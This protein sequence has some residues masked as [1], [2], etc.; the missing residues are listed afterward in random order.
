MSEIIPR[1]MRKH[2]NLIHFLCLKAYICHLGNLDYM[3]EEEKGNMEG[4]NSEN[5]KV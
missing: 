4:K 2:I 3:R 5:K 1:C